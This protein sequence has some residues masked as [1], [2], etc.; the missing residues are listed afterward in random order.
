[1]PPTKVPRPSPINPRTTIPLFRKVSNSGIQVL[2]PANATIIPV[3]SPISSASDAIPTNAAGPNVPT[4][5][6]RTKLTDK[7]RSTFDKASDTPV[8]FSTGNV[9]NPQRTRPKVTIIT[10][11]T[12]RPPIAVVA[13]FDMPII[14]AIIAMTTANA[15]VAPDNWLLSIMDNV[16]IDIV[17]IAIVDARM[18][19]VFSQLFA[20]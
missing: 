2:R 15:A 11:I 7:E 19:R 3:S 12:M 1:M 10:S 4:A 18:M 17:R 6:N 13:R 8:T 20:R 5:A 9:D 14:V 16:A